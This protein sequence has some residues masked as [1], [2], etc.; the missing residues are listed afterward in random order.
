MFI[1]STFIVIWL[2]LFL[3][4]FFLPVGHFRSFRITIP[5]SSCMN[6][7]QYNELPKCDW[8]SPSGIQDLDIHHFCIIR[9]FP[10]LEKS[11]LE[12]PNN[13]ANVAV[14]CLLGVRPIEQEIDLKKLSFLVSILY[15]DSSIE[16]ALAKRQMNPGR[17]APKPFRPLVVSPPRRF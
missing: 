11:I 8:P 3:R 10:A 17:F 2:F 7:V 5:T 9:W 15:N 1:Y 12:K 4:R 14:Y 6:T 16:A 13:T